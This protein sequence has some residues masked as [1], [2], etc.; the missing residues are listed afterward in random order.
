VNSR[1]STIDI[2]RFVAVALVLGRHSDYLNISDYGPVISTLSQAWITGGWVGVDLFFVLSGFLVSGLLFRE[3]KD[4]NVKRFLIRRGF[5]IYP[6][7]YV[8]IFATLASDLLA[9]ANVR[10]EAYSS[11]I[12]FLQSYFPH[13][14]PHTWSLAVEEHF[15]IL[16]PLG[17]LALKKLAPD[18]K[19]R[20][21]PVAVAAMC[22]A[23][24][25]GRIGLAASADIEASFREGYYFATHLRIDALAFGV[26][27]S[28][29]VHYSPSRLDFV[30]RHRRELSLFA[31][32]MIA[33]A[34]ALEVDQSFFIST[35]EY[36]LLYLAF[37]VLLIAALGS[38]RMTGVASG[39]I[40]RVAAY[41]GRHSYSVYLWHFPIKLITHQVFV[42]ILGANAG[43][44]V[45]GS[46][47][48]FAVYLIASFAA[49]IAMAKIIEFPALRLRERVFS[50]TSRQV[51]AEVPV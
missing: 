31:L 46:I 42:S 23:C 18:D 30:S 16:L 12:F 9:G 45:A 1:N 24:L 10:P 25:V 4:I 5:K 47:V 20:Q 13:V 44:M 37:G 28:Y 6:S 48:E 50:S 36:T 29:L 11:E 17:L 33:P 51:T 14:W 26:L 39:K 38:Q 32:L 3:G 49:G 43:S 2:F 7:F 8:L 21:L 15:Y 35:I 34:F 27:L 22:S 41:F 19:Y 40:G